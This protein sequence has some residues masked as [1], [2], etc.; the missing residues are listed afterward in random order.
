MCPDRLDLLPGG[1]LDS[2]AVFA[3]MDS[4]DSSDGSDGTTARL[5]G[6]DFG[7]DEQS[8]DSAEQPQDAAANNKRTSSQLPALSPSR[9]QL[10]KKKKVFSRKIYI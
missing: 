9:A 6:L 5:A 10:P 3:A 1:V 4:G 2:A 7:D 8:E